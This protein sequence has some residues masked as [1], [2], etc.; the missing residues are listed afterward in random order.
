MLVF[1]MGLL[2]FRKSSSVAPL[3]GFNGGGCETMP[4]LL[5]RGLMEVMAAPERGWTPSWTCARTFPSV[6]EG[7]EEQT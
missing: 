2:A 1:V 5:R 7:E 3:G 6:L 4:R